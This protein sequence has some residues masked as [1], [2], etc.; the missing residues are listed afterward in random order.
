MK[1]H[2]LT[3]ALAVL[4]VSIA[5]AQRKD[6]ALPQKATPQLLGVFKPAVDKA[7][8]STVVVYADDKQVALGAIVTADGYIISKASEIPEGKIVVKL[9]TGKEYL[10]KITASN[11]VY[12]VAVLKI[13]AD[14][15]P[16]I[17]WSLSKNA[18]VGNWI[19]ASGASADPV[20]VGIVG[21]A[22]RNFPG[23]HGASRVPS[24]NSGFLGVQ[25]DPDSAS[26]TISV[27]T[28]GSAA[29]KAGIK[30]KDVIISIDS[31][32]IVNQEALIN[33]LMGY[34]AGD[35]IK[36]K[37]EREGKR[38]EIPATL[39]K[40]PPALFPKGDARGEMQNKMGSI[41]SNRRTGFPTVLQHDIVLKPN[42]CGG[43]LVDLDGRVVGLNIAR[44]G[45][46][47]T[48]AIP[49]EVILQLLPD[50]LATKVAF[51]AEEQVVQAREALRRAE[52]AK[53][54]AD[55]LL[56][57]AKSR[58][59]RALSEEK[60]WRDRPIEKGPQPRV[61]NAK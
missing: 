29:E 56:V 7:A 1:R 60:W 22:A 13:E 35:V 33:T 28:A 42:E 14:N 34:K 17:D 38:M 50:L 37:L 27:V 41:L 26:A 31:T 48:Y 45:R 57:E 54:M 30:T 19:A 4:M 39:G 61:V 6:T 59:E 16:T 9:R 47:E 52:T 8:K 51:T 23:P 5:S 25:L 21:V 11:G 55:K 40:R 36:V 2:F 20:G 53:A 49:S 32:E 18:P 12:D 10:A 58:L 46:T 43:P 44:A 3:L 24:E 15:L